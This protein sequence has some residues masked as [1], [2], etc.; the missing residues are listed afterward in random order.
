MKDVVY[1]K[2]VHSDNIFT[3]VSDKPSIKDKEGDAIITNEKKVIVGVFTA[4]CVPIILVDEVNKVVAAI[5]SGW[6]GTFNSITFKTIAKMKKDYNCK[7]ENI[8][9]YIGPHIRE[10]CYEVSEELKA[11]FLNEKSDIDKEKLFNKN[12]LNLESCIISDLKKSGMLEN[13]INALG[14]CTYCNKEFKLHSYR[15]SKGDYG[16]MFAFVILE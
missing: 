2:Q 8:K 15:K 13:H 6:R 4:D 7:P 14:L 10:C 9:A 5:H 16:R 12:N 3:Y 11:R 1:L